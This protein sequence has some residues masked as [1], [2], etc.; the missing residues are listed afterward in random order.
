ME[1]RNLA[2]VKLVG[3]AIR[4]GWNV[5]DEIKLECVAQLAAIAAGA[6]KDSDRVAAIKALMVADSIDAKRD[7]DDEDRRLQLLELAQ[8]IPIGELTR[9]ASDHG[10]IVDGTTTRADE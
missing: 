10:I 4:K 5:P 9:L 1:I 7:K 8:R 2:D 3:R 6:E